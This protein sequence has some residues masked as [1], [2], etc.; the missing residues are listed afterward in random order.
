MP[1]IAILGLDGKVYEMT[2]FKDYQ[3]KVVNE[4]VQNKTLERS[5]G[6]GLF[7]P[8]GISNQ[9]V[10]NAII[11]R[12][13]PFL[14]DNIAEHYGVCFKNGKSLPQESI[15]R[16][17]G[18]FCEIVNNLSVELQLNADINETKTRLYNAIDARFLQ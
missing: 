10:Y 13:S 2:Q 11:E 18:G 12:L 3:D 7:V 17:V 1:V 16:S 6:G 15:D 9:E 8:T 5:S 14:N 4:L